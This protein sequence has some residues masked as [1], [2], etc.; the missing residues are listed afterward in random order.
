M[1]AKE[2]SF[3]NQGTKLSNKVLGKSTS[4]SATS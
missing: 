1:A 4:A 2:I 3:L